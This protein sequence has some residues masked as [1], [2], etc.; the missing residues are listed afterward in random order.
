MGEA[1]L[2]HAF[3]IKMHRLWHGKKEINAFWFECGKRVLL[4]WAALLMI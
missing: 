1:P 4:S 2:L 3:V